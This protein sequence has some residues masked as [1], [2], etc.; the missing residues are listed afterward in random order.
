MT[1]RRIALL[2]TFATA[3]A[4]FAALPG[5]ARSG[6]ARVAVSA[7]RAAAAS[8]RPL[9][10]GTPAGVLRLALEPNAILAPAAARR[11][12]ASGIDLSRTQTLRGTVLGDPSSIVRVTVTDSWASGYIMTAAGSLE[13][14]PASGAGVVAR[15]PRI[16]LSGPIDVEPGPG[17]PGTTDNH[18]LLG[19]LSAAPLHYALPD[20]LVFG[21]PSMEFKLA[22]GVDETFVTAYGADWASDALAIANGADGVYQQVGIDFSVVDIHSHGPLAGFAGNDPSALL[23]G[24][25][26]HYGGSH[27]G[28]GRDAVAMLFGKDFAAGVLGQAN[29][30]GGAGNP[31]V[32]YLV[33]QMVGVPPLNFGVTLYANAYV[34]ILAHELGHLFN[35][36]HHYGNCV[37][38]LIPTRGI[39]AN[40][41]GG[42]F[43]TLMFPSVDFLDETMGS[44]ERLVIR[45]WA[46]SAL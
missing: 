9:A 12:A 2:L 31:N 13:I 46:E 21:W 17:L 35:A 15:E 19:C 14:A 18:Q 1:R 32:A 45:G 25:S 38:S 8:G 10:V 34:K 40:P 5:S 26:N 20:G 41:D 44:F 42:D 23:N 4:T 28:I 27:V 37:D 16:A 24:T 33:G 6:P 7:W 43:C 30:I 3:L 29:C 11:L 22:I 36:H 39:D